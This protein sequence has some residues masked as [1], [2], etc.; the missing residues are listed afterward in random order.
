MEKIVSNAD[1]RTLDRVRKLLAKAEGTDNE[2]ERDTFMAAA[3]QLMAKYGIE[4][5]MLAA[6]DRSSE[7]P[8]NRRITVE[9]PW[10]DVK[11]NL[12][13][14][15]A[16]A[17]GC[18]SIMITGV[19]GCKV[20][21]I[22]GFESDLER[23][24][25]L[26]TSLLLQMASALTR[27]EIPYYDSPRAYRRSWMLGFKNEVVSRI[28]A[29]ERAAVR[30]YEADRPPASSATGPSTELVLASR[31]EAVDKAVAEVFPSLKRGNGLSSRGSGYGAGRAAGRQADIG[32]KR[33]GGGAQRSLRSA[34]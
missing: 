34:R 7:K 26:Y 30:E 13:Y 27:V 8:T 22:F 20:V 28:R 25:L 15:V 19:R 29:A 16:E 32:G 6:T 21:Q 33:V 1:E 14:N 4:Q 9:N 10:A 24:E 31:K 18:K 2:H 17:V 3:N 5:A 11:A 23:A 12:I